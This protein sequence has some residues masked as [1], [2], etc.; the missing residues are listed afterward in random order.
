MSIWKK[1]KLVKGAV[2]A[3][4]LA[5]G[6]LLNA[7]NN[8]LG[9]TPDE[10]YVGPDTPEVDTTKVDTT[11]TADSLDTWKPLAQ[12]YVNRYKLAE[13]N[14]QTFYYQDF[15]WYTIYSNDGTWSTT[16]A[17]TIV[18]MQLPNGQRS[19]LY[20]IHEWYDC[21]GNRAGMLFRNESDILYFTDGSKG[22]R[23][24]PENEQEPEK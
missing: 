24:V 4:A 12:L 18:F 15:G 3:A 9:V 7:C 21:D 6:A 5:T 17:P 20:P 11:K 8:P 2:M 19:A 1:S 14:H 23:A 13:D 10:P 22:C 16:S